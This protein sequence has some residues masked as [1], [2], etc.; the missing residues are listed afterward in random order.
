MAL[1]LEIEGPS[2]TP[3][4]NVKNPPS[5]ISCRLSLPANPVI[6]PGELVLRVCL[7]RLF[8]SVATN[9]NKNTLMQVD[10]G[11]WLED[12]ANQ[13]LGKDYFLN[14]SC[15]PNLWIADDVTLTARRRIDPGEE[16]TMDYAT[17]FADPGWTMR[18]SCN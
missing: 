1:L 6:V 18:N 12:P 10:E 4:A 15:D 16:V 9:A 8:D 5:H 2:S 7:A 11:R 13:P 3:T 14:H 17:H